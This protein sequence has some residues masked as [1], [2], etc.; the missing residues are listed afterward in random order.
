MGNLEKKVSSNSKKKLNP[1]LDK[2]IHSKFTFI[3]RNPVG[4]YFTGSYIP[5]PTQEAIAEEIG[6]PML[7]YSITSCIGNFIINA[8]KIYGGIKLLQHASTTSTT[9][10][11]RIEEVGATGLF[12]W[13]VKG[14][15]EIVIRGYYMYNTKKPIGGFTVEA[16]YH[17]GKGFFYGM[18]KMIEMTRKING[19][20]ENEEK[21]I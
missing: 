16:A 9:L 8:I 20:N 14:G 18:K 5:G 2:Y 15:L 11:E 19:N 1:L 12:L 13:T 7:L 6:R 4:W 10:L 3:T 17:G 21:D